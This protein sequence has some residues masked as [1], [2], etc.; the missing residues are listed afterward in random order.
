VINHFQRSPVKKRQFSDRSPSVLHRSPDKLQEERYLEGCRGREQVDAGC[1]P[2][3]LAFLAAVSLALALAFLKRWRRWQL[4][5]CN[6]GGAG[7]LAPSRVV[8]ASG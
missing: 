4:D 3:G 2:V 8:S 6:V 5:S 1:V 7:P